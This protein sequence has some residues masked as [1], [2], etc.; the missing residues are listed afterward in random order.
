M[1]RSGPVRRPTLQTVAARANVS[2]ATA[3]RV[4]TGSPLASP[5][6]RERVTA[7]AQ[8]L[9]Y[10]P[11]RLARGLTK[12]RTGSVAVVSCAATGSWDPF[13]VELA[14]RISRELARVD[15]HALWATAPIGPRYRRAEE[16]LTGGSVDG[17]VLLA[18][19][20]GHPLPAALLRAGIP[21]VVSGRPPDPSLGLP[22]VDADNRRGAEV[23]VHWLRQ[24]GRTRIGTVTGSQTMTAG[25][26]R[27]AGYLAGLEI[28]ASARRWPALTASG[29]F[30]AR[31][32][33]RAMD[34]LLRRDA[35]LD[36]VFVASDLM[37]LGALKA[38]I[39]AGRRVPDDVAVVGFDGL[40]S[41]AEI[42]SGPSLTSVRQPIAGMGRELAQ[43]LAARADASSPQAGPVADSRI[44]PT[45]MLLGHTA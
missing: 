39:R 8:A 28:P 19:H 18:L 7:A 23:A 37:A 43:L 6:A 15:L 2:R 14:A 25:V 13:E 10:V 41:L 30:T 40:D 36:A 9:G 5:Q 11:N 3:S 4:L 35:R 38:L 33:E 16:Y 42:W 17:V 27:L 20:T 1:G 44:L 24:R 26:D 12:R 22:Y 29:H 34:A 21:T 45:E 31:G 32:G